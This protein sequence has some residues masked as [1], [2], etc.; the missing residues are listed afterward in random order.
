MCTI[1]NEYVFLGS[2]IGDSVLIRYQEKSE[3]ATS[4]TA[5]TSSTTDSKVCCCIEPLWNVIITV[6]A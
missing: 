4:A 6:S 2:R 3:P 1:G 5:A